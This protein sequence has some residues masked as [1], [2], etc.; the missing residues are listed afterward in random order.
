MDTIHPIF[1][2]IFSGYIEKLEKCE[3]CNGQG[4]LRYDP[5]G[6]DGDVEEFDCPVCEAKGET[7]HENNEKLKW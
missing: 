6:P 2:E 3:W 1:R 5:S 4:F 7:T